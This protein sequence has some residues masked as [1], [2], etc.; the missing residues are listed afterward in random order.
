MLQGRETASHNHISNYSLSI[1]EASQMSVL[2][3]AQ[4]SPLPPIFT[5][6][7]MESPTTVSMST[8]PTWVF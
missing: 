8:I 1:C 4:S 6:S 3:D 5:L 2:E 7:I